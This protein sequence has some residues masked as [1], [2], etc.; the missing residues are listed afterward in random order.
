MY[1]FKFRATIFFQASTAEK[2]EWFV[3]GNLKTVSVQQNSGMTTAQFDIKV[4]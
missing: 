2:A 4:L 3:D 1:L